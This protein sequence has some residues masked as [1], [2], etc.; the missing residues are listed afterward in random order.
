MHSEARRGA[1]R[2]LPIKLV[3]RTMFPLIYRPVNTG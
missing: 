1:F 2:R 3:Q